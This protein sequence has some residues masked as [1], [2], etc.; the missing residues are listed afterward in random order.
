VTTP[1]QPALDDLRGRFLRAQLDGDRRQALALVSDARGDEAL[2]AA[3]IRAH[4][5][6]A[7][8]REIGALWQRNEISIAQEHMA[9]AIS[10]L[11]LSELFQHDTPAAPNGRKVIVACVD[12]ELHDFP[13]RLVADE[14]DVAGFDVRFLGASVPLD[15]MLSFIAREDPD[16]LVISATMAFHADNVRA[17]VAQIRRLAPSLPIAVGGQVCQWVA[18]LG[19]ELGL[20]LSGGSAADLVNHAKRVLRVAS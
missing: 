1:H 15:A 10:Q 7:A 12:G 6:G 3:D 19:Q 5:I 16:L 4:V 13:A 8:Q 9:T 11:A 2:S 18:T 17:A 14:L 20:E